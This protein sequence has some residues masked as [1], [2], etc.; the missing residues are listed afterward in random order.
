MEKVLKERQ[1]FGRF[2]YRFPNG[3][4]VRCH[5][6]PPLTPLPPMPLPPPPPAPSVFKHTH[7]LL[8]H[9]LTH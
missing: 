6:Y 5:P 3:E 1:R 7:R 9:S 8:P 4:A 2:Y